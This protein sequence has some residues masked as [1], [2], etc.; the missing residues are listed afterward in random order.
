MLSK[1]LN[2]VLQGWPSV[3]DGEFTAYSRKKDEL[4]VE[5]GCLLWGSCVIIPAPGREELLNKHHE[6][7]PGIVRMKAL[8]CSYL[9]WP[10]LDAEIELKVHS[11]AVCQEHS[12]LPANANLHPWEW[13]GKTW[14]RM[15][16]DYAG[17]FEWKIILVI[18]D[19]HSKYIDAHVMTSLTTAATILRLRQTFATHGLPCT[20][21]SDNGTAFTS[22]KF[23]NFYRSSGINHIHSAPFHPA[24]NGLAERAAETIKD[25]LKKIKGGDLET[26]MYQFLSRYRVTPQMTTGQMPAEMLMSKRTRFRLDLLYPAVEDRVLN[27]QAK[28]QE[29]HNAAVTERTFLTGDAVWAMN[30]AT[31]PKWL[32]GVLQ[33]R[34]GPVS[35]TVTLTDGRVWRCHVDHLRAHIPEENVGMTLPLPSSVGVVP[36]MEGVKLAPSPVVKS[37]SCETVITSCTLDWIG[38]INHL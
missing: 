30:F 21:V 1:V 22:H 36:P 33:T 13:P 15:H 14:Y 32:P 7:H 38:F 37:P 2:F 6:Y 12:K 5:Q 35:F 34:L 27:K 9:W 16:I 31:K 17:P 20:L 3:F 23:Q 19:A 10:G 24:S 4:S 28:A 25:G 11:C 29:N 26:R 8:V 18:V